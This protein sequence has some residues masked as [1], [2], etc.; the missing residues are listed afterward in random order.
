VAY[1]QASYAGA[2]R[3]RRRAQSGWNTASM[4]QVT[5]RASA[6]SAMAAPTKAQMSATTPPERVGADP[7]GLSVT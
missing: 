1:V 7:A 2:L 5:R 3:R 4:S 6:D